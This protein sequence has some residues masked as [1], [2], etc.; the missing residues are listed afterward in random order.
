MSDLCEPIELGA[1]GTIRFGGATCQKTG[2]TVNGPALRR[3]KGNCRLLAT[4]CALNRNLDALPH[5]GSLR[6]GDGSQPFILRLLARL[7]T[8]RFVLQSLVMEKCLFAGSPD[9]ILVTVYALDA[10]VWMFG[11]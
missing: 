5:A 9:E 1:G 11:V 6:G 8:L 10:A 7:A 3:I 4:L 2:A